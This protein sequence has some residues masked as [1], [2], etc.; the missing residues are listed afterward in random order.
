MSDAPDE[1]TADE[2]EDDE[3]EA[4]ETRRRGPSIPVLVFLVIAFMGLASAVT[5]RWDHRQ[6]DFG[7]VD[8]G[9]FDDMTT[10]HLQ[11]ID[12]AT[13]YT[14]YGVDPVLLGDAS[15]IVFNQAGDIR[16]MRRALGDW[17]RSGT[18][19]VAM[20]WMGM[21]SPQDAQPGMAT[22]EQVA[23]LMRAR[24]RRLD[25]LFSAL[26]INHHAG[27]LHMAAYAGAH[28]K[29]SLVRSLARF[30]ERDQRF[31][32]AD[33]NLWRQKLGFAEHPPGAAVVISEP[34][35]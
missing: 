6:A 34:T 23:A 12:L 18:P 33:M 8:V 28:A 24:G 16:Q 5:Y 19:D 20:E 13:V 21:H 27:G 25:D 22:P 11:A 35:G 31:E 30:M 3:Y 32:I 15:K 9:F 1:V 26:M 7:A 14:R 2:V 4:D 17:R 10:H 29:T